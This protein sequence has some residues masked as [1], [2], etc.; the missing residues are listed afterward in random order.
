MKRT[1]CNDRPTMEPSAPRRHQN[2]PE[3]SLPIGVVGDARPIEVGVAVLSQLIE[4]SPVATLVVDEDLRVVAHNPSAA[5][6][7]STHSVDLAT[8]RFPHP[9]GGE[10][11]ELA[12]ADDVGVRRLHHVVCRP[13]VGWGRAAWLVTI[14]AG[15]IDAEPIDVGPNDDTHDRLTGLAGREL[16]LNRLADAVRRRGSNDAV[17]VAVIAIDLD[18]F[19]RVNERHGTATGDR[20]LRAIAN[21]LTVA[22]L[23]G[24]YVSRTGGDE[25]AV[26]L[27][28]RR[29]AEHLDV[30]DRIAS[31]LSQPIEIDGVEHL[32]SPVIGVAEAIDGDDEH[33]LLAAAE[34]A[35]SVAIPATP[36]LARR[37]LEALDPRGVLRSSL[38]TAAAEGQMFLQYQPIFAL[39][40]R[41]LVGLEA[42]VRW[43][44]PDDG[45]IAPDEFIRIA[46]ESG[47]IIPLGEWVFAEVCAQLAEWRST[48]RGCVVPPV[49]INVTGRQL[50]DRA[51][52]SHALD[53]LAARSLSPSAIRLEITEQALMDH[54]PHVAEVLRQLAADGFAIDL[55]DFGTGVSSLTRLLEHPVS[56]LKV[57]RSVVGRLMH[58]ETSRKIILAAIEIGRAVELPVTAIGV[59]QADQ[60]ALLDRWGCDRAQGYVMARPLNP[61]E[62]SRFFHRDPRSLP[63]REPRGPILRSGMRAPAGIEL[64]SDWS[65]ASFAVN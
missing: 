50:A 10:P 46:D 60:C 33:A 26:L 52:R 48:A 53:E 38:P 57:P 47:A 54:D 5:R 45:L 1:T 3:R 13:L 36:R 7:L 43:E 28:P 58:D 32:S 63:V 16:L 37:H 4:A 42:L 40:D 8:S 19:C 11:Y 24:D 6:T 55:D 2:E 23:P 30:A 15:A 35:A 64:A 62:A 29:T 9:V 14:A 49:S 25:F 39:G 21:R 59:E 12:L 20:I 61:I 27:A 17:H 18:R 34:E 41:S 44:H 65:V 56:G 31:V 51:F 22:V